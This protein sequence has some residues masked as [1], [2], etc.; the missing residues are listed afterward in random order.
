MLTNTL[1]K[2]IICDYKTKNTILN[3]TTLHNYLKNLTISEHFYNCNLS[4]VKGDIFENIAKFY[5]ESCGY[6]VYMYSNIPLLLKEKLHLPN[7]DKGIDLIYKNNDEWFGVQCKWRELKTRCIDKNLIEGSY[8]QFEKSNLNKYVVFTNVNKKTN[9]CVKDIIWFLGLSFRQI[10]NGIFI[11][12]ML[13]KV[14]IKPNVEDHKIHNLRDYQI[15]AIDKLF[16]CKEKNKQC[17]MFCGTGKSIVMIEYMKKVSLNKVVILMPSLQLI[18]QFYKN[19]HANYP[20]LNTLCICSQLDKAS[21]SCGETDEKQ[22]NELLD[23]FLAMNDDVRYTTKPVEITK[24]LKSEKLVVLCTYQ[25]SKL[26]KGYKFDLGIFDE[27]H[28]TVNNDNFGFCLK[29]EN[30]EIGERVYFTATPRYYGGK[31]E[32]CVSMDNKDIYGN[33]VFEYNY[34]QA[35]ENKHV[36]DYRVISYVVPKDLEKIVTEKYIKNDELKINGMDTFINSNMFL[37]A[38]QVAQHITTGEC[39]KLLTYHNSVNDA[40]EFKKILNYV[41]NLDEFKIN[42]SVFCMSGKTKMNIR[43]EIF[44]EF[45]NCKYGIICS[46]KVLNEGIDLPCV[47]SVVFVDSRS[48]T[49]DVTQCIGRG[50]RLYNEFGI[51]NI[52]IPIHYDHIEEKHNYRVIFDILTAMNEFDSKLIE[53]FATKHINNKIVIKGMNVIDV[54]RDNNG[55]IIFDVDEITKGLNNC[56]VSSDRLNFSYKMAILIDFCKNNTRCPLK[57]EI[58]KEIN[59]YTFFKYIK[60]NLKYKDNKIYIPLSV[61]EFMKINMD[62]NLLSKETSIDEKWEIKKEALFKYC[63]DSKQNNPN[64]KIIF[65]KESSW[66]DTQKKEINTRDNEKYKKLSTNKHVKDE[67]DRYLDIKEKNKG[68]VK[69]S[70]ETNKELLFDYCDANKKVPLRKENRWYGYEKEKI[71]TIEDDNYIKFS[72]NLYVKNDIDRYLANKDSWERNKNELF[73]YCNNNNGK[74]PKYNGWLKFQKESIN[75]IE[76]ESYKKLSQNQYVKIELDRYLKDKPNRKKNNKK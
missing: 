58:H 11:D 57:D 64:K 26:L 67:L 55:D 70:W 9:S 43:K 33:I 71:Q 65:S 21:L 2:E 13:D 76:D 5:Y 54:V 6:E 69:N 32:K 14:V 61:Y 22:A 47:D 24:K 59:V 18:S 3:E 66:F 74:M 38:L 7:Q 16:D 29:N 41:F 27:A 73:E 40:N 10:I 49:I 35:R 30:C 17:I 53:Y 63:N 36:L 72:K 75:S 45:T 52:I 39:F 44:D 62:K 31:D 60:A 15:E 28:K 46:S 1:F 48:S 25:S 68:K 12:Y 50:M 8:A 34:A 56:V 19:L 20:G 42:A 23:E 4:K 51:C 37:S